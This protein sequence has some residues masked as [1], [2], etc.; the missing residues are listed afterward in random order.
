MA[1]Y[2]FD[3]SGVRRIVGAVRRVE[4]SSRTNPLILPPMVSSG[5]AENWLTGVNKAGKVIPAHSCV[6][7][8]EGELVDDVYH[9]DLTEPSTTFTR[10]YGLTVGLDIDED[11]ELGFHMEAGFATYDA[12]DAPA[13]GDTVGPKPGSFLLWK[14]YPGFRVLQIVDEDNHIMLATREEIPWYRCKPDADIA[15]GSS[16]TVSIYNGADPPVDTGINVTAKAT[17]NAVTSGKWCSVD[18]YGGTARVNK[19]EC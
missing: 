17:D 11:D 8:E 7:V 15:K 4:G 18:F 9:N 12:T 14:N 1:G 13:V 5:T 6:R 19:L 10:S 16:G 2:K 3:E